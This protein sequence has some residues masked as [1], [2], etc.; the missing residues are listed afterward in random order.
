[1]YNVVSKH[2]LT[3]NLQHGTQR[4]QL[5]P[6]TCTRDTLMSSY[7]SVYFLQLS[8]QLGVICMQFGRSDSSCKDVI[9]VLKAKVVLSPFP[10]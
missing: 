6:T 3:N 2:P 9:R 7:I 4:G 8:R 10:K 1:M 5:L